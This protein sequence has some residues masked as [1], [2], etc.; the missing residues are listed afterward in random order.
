VLYKEVEPV[1]CIEKKK[2]YSPLDGIANISQIATFCL[3]HADIL[4]GIERIKI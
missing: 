1:A 3:D 2:E 4:T